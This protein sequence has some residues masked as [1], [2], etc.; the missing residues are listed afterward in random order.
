MVPGTKSDRLLTDGEQSVR[1]RNRVIKPG[2]APLSPRH[3]T[4]AVV[5]QLERSIMEE[6][7]PTEE[8]RSGELG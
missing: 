5:A 8:S 1:A 2:Q 6:V 4:S 7:R 3:S